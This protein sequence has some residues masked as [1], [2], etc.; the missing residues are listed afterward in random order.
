MTTKLTASDR[1]RSEG[2]A[3]REPVQPLEGV[4]A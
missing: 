3:P 4:E 1:A 2:V